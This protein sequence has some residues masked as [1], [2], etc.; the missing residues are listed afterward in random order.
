V[1][2]GGAAVVGAAGG[3]GTG[4]GVVC[5]TAAEVAVV[6]P[7]EAGTV[8]VVSPFAAEVPGATTV[9][10]VSTLVLLSSPPLAAFTEKPT[11]SPSATP[12]AI[13]L[14]NHLRG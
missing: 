5:A 2:A 6:S 1:G 10:P 9:V 11:T 7:P 13:E 14:V 12:P 3:G 8:T 4:T